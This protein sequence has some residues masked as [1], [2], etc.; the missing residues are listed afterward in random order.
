MEDQGIQG[1]QAGTRK[2]FVTGTPFESSP[3]QIAGWV[4]TLDNGSWTGPQRFPDW[5]LKE[6]YRRNLRYCTFNSLKD[7]GKA[8]VK[9]VTS[10]EKDKN[11]EA[12]HAKNVVRVAST[13]F[14]RRDSAKSTF[15]GSLL[16]AVPYNEHTVINC[17]LPT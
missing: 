9:L 7:L 16:T 11:A 12:T 2:W 5:P 4:D 1:I 10:K 15:L 6:N 13:L 14:I 17:P 3:S 8:H